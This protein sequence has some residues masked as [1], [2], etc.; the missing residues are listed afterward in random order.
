MEVQWLL[1]CCCLISEFPGGN[2]GKTETETCK[3][4]VVNFNSFYFKFNSFNFKFLAVK[5]LPFRRI[6]CREKKVT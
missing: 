2:G 4:L 3:F 5:K 1:L 6:E